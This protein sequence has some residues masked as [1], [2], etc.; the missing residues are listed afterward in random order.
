MTRINFK[1]RI[2]NMRT[3]YYYKTHDKQ[4]YFIILYFFYHIPIMT[5]PLLTLLT[6]VII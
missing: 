5:S 1:F 4:I 6:N 3:F 2:N